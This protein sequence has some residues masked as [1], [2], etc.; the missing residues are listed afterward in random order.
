MNTNISVALVVMVVH[1]IMLVKN[2]KL[3]ADADAPSLKGLTANMTRIVIIR[4]AYNSN[5][6]FFKPIMQKPVHD[7]LL[8]VPF[9][10]V[11][12]P[13]PFKPGNVPK[14]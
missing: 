2:N 1:P 10:I 13:V 4:A 8:M 9:P 6:V 11:I 5:S 14:F 3:I 7:I 12:P